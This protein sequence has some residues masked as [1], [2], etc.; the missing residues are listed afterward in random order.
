MSSCSNTTSTVMVT[1]NYF[2]Y[3]RIDNGQ[4]LI[5]FEKFD[6]KNIRLVYKACPTPTMILH[7]GVSIPTYHT[8]FLNDYEKPRTSLKIST[9]QMLLPFFV[10]YTP[11]IRRVD[12]KNIKPVVLDS[13]CGVYN[14]ELQA[15]AWSIPF[16]AHFT[17]FICK[18]LSSYKT[19][20]LPIYHHQ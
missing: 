7:A 16:L 2:Y 17:L 4:F 12:D 18:P 8:T 14:K 20:T 9:T 11:T 1:C 15:G 10:M 6:M 3:T 19:V 13:H 5:F